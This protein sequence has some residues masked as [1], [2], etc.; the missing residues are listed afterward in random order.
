MAAGVVWLDTLTGWLGGWGTQPLSLEEL[1]KKRSEKAA[2][3]AKVS[4]CG[5]SCTNALGHEQIHL[6]RFPPGGYS[7]QRA[8]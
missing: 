8:C 4:A 5:P 1:L 6:T 7:G 3:D 2:A